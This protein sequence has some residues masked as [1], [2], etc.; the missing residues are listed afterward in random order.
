MVL[1]EAPCQKFEGKIMEL[2][3]R[4]ATWNNIRSLLQ[5]RD[6]TAMLAEWRIF[7]QEGIPSISKPN[8]F[9]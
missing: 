6:D 4:K 5:H 1:V 2:K 9:A 3:H 8:E 7:F